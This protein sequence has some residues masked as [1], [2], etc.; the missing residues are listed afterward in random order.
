MTLWELYGIIVTN[1][2]SSDNFDLPYQI[3]TRSMKLF[4]G[5]RQKFMCVLV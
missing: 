2:E 4:A 1:S 3:S 5:Y